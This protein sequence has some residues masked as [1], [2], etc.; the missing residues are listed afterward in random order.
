MRLRPFQLSAVSADNQNEDTAMEKQ[1]Y[2]SNWNTYQD[3]WAD[4]SAAERQELLGRVMAEGYTF[5][6]PGGEGR[7][8][9]ELAAHIAVF[10][11]QYPGASFKTHSMIVHH[12]QALAEWIMYD[13]DGAE[14]L[15]GK[16]YVRFGEDGRLLQLVGFW[17]A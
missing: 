6:S 3:A 7:G 15:P 13:K 1:I 5:E 14:Y 11:K 4:I 8:L 9:A 16:S 2:E 17:Q 10:Q 12:E